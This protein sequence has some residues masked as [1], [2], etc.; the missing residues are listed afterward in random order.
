MAEFP[1]IEDADGAPYPDEAQAVFRAVLTDVLSAMQEHIKSYRGGPMIPV[2]TVLDVIEQQKPPPPAIVHACPIGDDGL[3]PC[4]HRT[5]F[6]LLN[7]RITLNIGD[8]TCTDRR[9]WVVKP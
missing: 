6:E 7:E 3:T 1:L 4:C 2:E 9:N 5:P 8:V